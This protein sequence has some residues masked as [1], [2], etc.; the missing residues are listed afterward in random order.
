[1]CILFSDLVYSPLMIQNANN[2]KI[3]QPLYCN[4]ELDFNIEIRRSSS[5]TKMIAARLNP[6]R[7]TDRAPS[8]LG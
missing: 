3:H 5:R 6:S 8:L 1:M 4:A 7:V 2:A